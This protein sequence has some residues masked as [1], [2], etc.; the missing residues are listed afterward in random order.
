MQV[1][2]NGKHSDQFSTAFIMSWN[3]VEFVI[4]DLRHISV[5]SSWERERYGGYSRGRN[6]EDSRED[7]LLSVRDSDRTQPSQ[8]LCGMSENSD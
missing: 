8:P 4:T 2:F 3:Y 5:L 7:S 1:K 6:G